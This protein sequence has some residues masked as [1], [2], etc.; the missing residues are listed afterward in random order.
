MKA[1]AVQ[2]TDSA[3]GTTGTYRLMW[4]D[5]AL[6][7]AAEFSDTQLNALH[8]DNDSWLWEDDS[9]EIM[10]DTLHD[11]GNPI[12]SDDY[13]FFVNAHNAHLDSQG[14]DSNWDSGL[15]SEVVVSGTV[16]QNS[17][18]DTGYV[19]EARIPWWVTGPGVGDAWGM[20]IQLNDMTA[21]GMHSTQWSES[22]LGV[23]IPDGW[24]DALFT[25]RADNN[26]KDGCI[27]EHELIP[28]IDLWKY[29]STAYPMGEVMEAVTLWSRGTGCT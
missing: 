1:Y 5:Q 7:I 10:F 9:L 29:D 21:T 22:G 19:V 12:Q 27:E 6:Y 23:N 4:D 26:P 28:F 18:T 2:L 16:N 13:K 20:N 25:V 24:N 11:K 3:T 8:T 17:D 15:A 14:Y